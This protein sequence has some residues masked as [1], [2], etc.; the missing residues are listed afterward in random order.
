MAKRP[1]VCARSCRACSTRT[2]INCGPFGNW[3][4]QLLV[5]QNV[6]SVFPLHRTA[7]NLCSSRSLL[8][9]QG[10]WGKG[11][12]AHCT[13]NA[14]ESRQPKSSH[15]RVRE[16]H[17]VIVQTSKLYVDFMQNPRTLAHRVSSRGDWDNRHR[18][19]DFCLCRCWTQSQ[20][21]HETDPGPLTPFLYWSPSKAPEENGRVPL[22]GMCS[23]AWPRARKQGGQ[24]GGWVLG[25]TVSETARHKRLGQHAQSVIRW[26]AHRRE[27]GTG[28]PPWR[29][30]LER[31]RQ[32]CLLGDSD[33]PNRSPQRALGMVSLLC[34][35]AKT[36]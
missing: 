14:G 18:V 8:S 34:W 32:N 10:L 3:M 9:L 2:E 4:L 5:G 21:E 24:K 11:G 23:L 19:T 25:L 26:A 29:S 33:S 12:R 13:G 7:Q 36:L 35:F 22:Q 31:G 27:G 6:R 20:L 17:K 30:Y 28:F 15:Q 16:P 1:R